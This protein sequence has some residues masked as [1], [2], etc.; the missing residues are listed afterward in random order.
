MKKF[1][2]A[3]A[4]GGAL[5][6]ASGAAQAKTYTLTL[7]GASPGGLWSLL[8]A[9]VDAAVKA[10]YPGSTITYQTSG[11]G[12]ANVGLLRAKKC[13]LAIVHDVE[14][15]LAMEGKKPF[16]KP[17]NDLRAIAVLYNWAPMQYVITKKFA[18]KHGINSFED[19]VKNKAP[20]RI[21]VN[22]RGNV[23]SQVIETMFKAAGASFA[24]IKSW[25]GQVVFAASKEMSNLIKDRR[26][27]AFGNAVFVRHRSVRQPGEA[28]PLKLLN[29]SDATIA[30][31]SDALKVGKFTI[32][33]GSYKWAP[34]NVNTVALSAQL[35]ALSSFSAA[36]A[37]NIT[38][39]L[40]D[41]AAKMSG[42]HRAMKKLDTK[43]M[44]SSKSTPYHPGAAK[45]Y[46]AAGLQ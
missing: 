29:V 25:G 4:V 44:A 39:A 18:D 45:A 5:I 20:V 17:A 40:I 28:V 27:D 38:K 42:V 1:I 36:D 10:A 6:A 30:K 43:L 9:G 11:G 12:F 19:I 26:I 15:K 21:A 22:K 14:A 37:H 41:N 24:D 32:K 3:C 46:K 7:C 8:G 33:G 23:V 31:V 2:A 34:D 16:S 35:V 13:D